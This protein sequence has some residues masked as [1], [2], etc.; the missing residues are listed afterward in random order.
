[1]TF[2][3]G[4]RNPQALAL[5]PVTNKLWS[6]VNER[7][8]IGDELVPDYLA[9]VNSGEFYGWPYVYLAPGN[10]D[11]RARPNDHTKANAHG[12]ADHHHCPPQLPPLGG[13]LAERRH[14]SADHTH[15]CACTQTAN[16]RVG[17]YNQ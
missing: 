8:G 6:Y 1:M 5:E 2:A 12:A 15:A 16:S 14:G 4:L 11:P 3:E 7:D 10:P 13:A 17:A 9:Q